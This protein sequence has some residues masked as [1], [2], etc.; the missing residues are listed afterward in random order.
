MK[1]RMTAAAKCR[2][3]AAAHDQWAYEV[4]DGIG[5]GAC[6]V[7]ALALAYM[8]LAL[9]APSEERKYR[10]IRHLQDT[11]QGAQ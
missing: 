3:R 1:A 10:E 8:A 2:A 7:A 4:L 6:I 5:I 11:A 9:N